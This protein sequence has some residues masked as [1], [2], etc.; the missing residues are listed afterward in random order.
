MVRKSSRLCNFSNIIN[1]KFNMVFISQKSRNLFLCL[2]MFITAIL[3]QNFFNKFFRKFS[4]T[5]K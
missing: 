4:I 2:A 5:I 3:L 1:C